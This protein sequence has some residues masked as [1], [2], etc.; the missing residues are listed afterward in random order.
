MDRQ[1]FHCGRNTFGWSEHQVSL[2]SVGWSAFVVE[3]CIRHFMA[4]RNCFAWNVRTDSS[5]WCALPAELEY[6]T[7]W[8][9]SSLPPIQS[10]CG[11]LLKGPDVFPGL[12]DGRDGAAA[13]MGE[14]LLAGSVFAI[15]LLWLLVC[16]A[17]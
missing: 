1:L 3:F 12:Q 17:A 5:S 7:K 8:I 15:V 14:G 10:Q 16:V 11:I 9:S 4:P 13:R 6:K 2:R